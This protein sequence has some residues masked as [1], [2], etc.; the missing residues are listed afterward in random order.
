MFQPSRE[1]SEKYGM[2]HWDRM[3]ELAALTMTALALVG[4]FL[5]ILFF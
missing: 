2:T 5:K 1:D 3:F 4:F